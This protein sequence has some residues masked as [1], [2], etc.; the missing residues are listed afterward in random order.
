MVGLELLK[1]G[2]YVA[3]RKNIAG[4]EQ[5]WNSID[6][7]CSRAGH[8]VCRSRADR[9]RARKSAKPVTHLREGRRCVDH[10]LFV[11]RQIVSER[12]GLLEGLTVSCYVAVT[13]DAP[14]SGEEGCLASIALDI[15]LSEEPRERLRH[16]QSSS[17]HACLRSSFECIACST[18][19]P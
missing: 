8:H 2:S 14:Y 11:T 9:R 16:R 3:A 5:H 12:R 7:G 17:L 10:R 15:L 1:H 13:E 19:H 18:V 6:R 4:Q